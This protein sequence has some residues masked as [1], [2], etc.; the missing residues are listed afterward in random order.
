MDK[1]VAKLDRLYPKIKIGK[2]CHMCNKPATDVHHIVRRDNYVLRF[3]LNNLLPLCRDCHRLIHDKGEEA[4]L[5]I[6]WSRAEYLRTLKN[7]QLQDYLLINGLT[8]EEFFKRKERELLE[9][10]CNV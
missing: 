2:H 7:I 6:S 8:K 5:Y 10:I 3:D 1:M 9:E 4:L